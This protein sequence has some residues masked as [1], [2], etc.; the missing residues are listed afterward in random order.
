MCFKA[1][2]QVAAFFVVYG[3]N[4]LMLSRVSGLFIVASFLFLYVFTLPP[5]VLTADNAEFQLIATNLGVAHPPGFPLYTLLAHLATWLPIGASPA[6]RINLFSVVTSTLTL[7]FVYLTV[8]RLTK[9]AW[10]AVTAVIALGTAATFWAQATTANIRSLTALFAAM[11]IYWLIRFQETGGEGRVMRGESPPRLRTFAPPLLFAALSLS[12][13]ITHHASLVFMGI[14]FGIYVLLVEPTLIRTPRWWLRLFFFSLLSFLPLLYIPWRAS[15]GA[16]RAPARLATWDGFWNHVLA[17][18]FSGDFFYFI[19]ALD[20]WERLKIMGNVMTF[21]FA[22]FLLIGMAIGL[23]LMLWH[24]WKVAL[25]CGGSF[26]IH[27]LITATYRAPQTVEYMLPAYIPAVICLGYGIGRLE[28]GDWRLEIRGWKLNDVY[29]TRSGRLATLLIT[30]YCT[31]LLLTALY[32]GWQNYPSFAELHRDLSS[33]DYAQ[34]LLDNA[35]PNSTMLAHWHW[36][37][38]LWYL[39][40]VGGQ[41]PDVITQF[42]FPTAEAYPETWARRVGEELAAGQDVITTHYDANFYETLP[43]P[44]PIAEGFLFRQQPRTSLPKNLVSLDLTLADTLHILGYQ[45][46]SNYFAIG[47]EATFTIAWEPGDSCALSTCLQEPVMLFAHLVG[48]DGL[49]YAQ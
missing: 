25:L 41:R 35:P 33:Y 46:A 13:G 8:H 29:R 18:G 40:E 19:E 9:S 17:R 10:G 5:G 24:N 16:D 42:V 43:L 48:S 22:P 32:Q 15:I 49:I 23:L 21:Q 2:T 4:P 7:I 26:A 12:F 30:V 20:F 14:V 28:S 27:T 3:Y 39:Q 47:Q 34:L 45:A 11:T 36:A 31:L 6:Y 38:T 1:V 44:E 37:T